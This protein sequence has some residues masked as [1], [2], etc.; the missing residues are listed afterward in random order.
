MI[1]TL[2]P[3]HKSQ[4]NAVISFYFSEMGIDEND[5]NSFEIK[6]PEKTLRALEATK[7]ILNG[8]QLGLA[9]KNQLKSDDTWE[10]GVEKMEKLINGSDALIFQGIRMEQEALKAHLL[11]Q[12]NE[13]IALVQSQQATSSSSASLI[14][15]KANQEKDNEIF[16]RLGEGFKIFNN[17]P[18]L[19]TAPKIDFPSELPRLLLHAS[20]SLKIES[21]FPK[22]QPDNIWK[23]IE[24]FGSGTMKKFK[25]NS[26]P[27]PQTS[28]KKID[29]KNDKNEQRRQDL[30]RVMLKAKA[31]S[32]NNNA[33]I[34]KDT[35]PKLNTLRT[36]KK[37]HPIPSKIPSPSPSPL[38]W[39]IK[40]VDP[41]EK[42]AYFGKSPSLIEHA[43]KT[44][45]RGKFRV[46]LSKKQNLNFPWKGGKSGKSI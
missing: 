5:N 1:A 15:A 21:I 13:K 23:D 24:S 28:D 10:G 37:Y 30:S 46:V 2:S 36:T 45:K 6:N 4:T 18:P 42:I 16:S 34:K 22:I 19:F 32:V 44:Q 40:T 11:E 31:L 26:L 27:N 25:F 29:I 33:G 20:Q 17:I 41:R 38:S 39:P 12:T 8:N 9:E 3:F 14:E 43:R 7:K 35:P